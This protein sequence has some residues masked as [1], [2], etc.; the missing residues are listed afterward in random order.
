MKRASPLSRNLVRA[1][2][3]PVEPL[4]AGAAL[5]LDRKGRVHARRT[6]AAWPFSEAR[7]GE[8]AGALSPEP[9]GRFLKRLWDS[10]TEAPTGG[11]VDHIGLPAPDGT[12]RRLS[13]RVGS[14]QRHPSLFTV[15]VRDVTE[16]HRHIDELAGEVERLRQ[17][18]RRR[19]ESMRGLAH[20]IRSPLSGLRGV[21]ALL[22]RSAGKT[23]SER[24]AALMKHCRMGAERLEDVVLAAMEGRAPTATARATGVLDLA[25]AVLFDLRHADPVVP[26]VW[27]AEGP[28]VQAAIPTYVLWR[29]LW[30]LAVN[31][32]VYRS[33]VRPLSVVLRTLGSVDRC[34]I[35]L[36]DNGIGLVPG[37]EEEIFD[38]GR[39][40]SNISGAPGTGL[41]LYHARAQVEEWGGQLW[42]EARPVGAAFLISLPLAPEGR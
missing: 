34:V 6:D 29:V 7:V 16:V 3:R 12:I 1:C 20:D 32:V 27:S 26:F 21:L 40:G 15:T 35:E 24:D 18:N 2:R 31:A 38:R 17:D 42:A 13:V 36:R 39:R 25:S 19:E 9:L 41:G 22:D 4:T 37:E 11:A 10:A 33:P 14:W 8:P 5:I 30:D 23:L 28:D